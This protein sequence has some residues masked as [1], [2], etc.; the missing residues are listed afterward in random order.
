[1]QVKC[2]HPQCM[3]AVPEGKEYCG[4]WCEKHAR[5]EVPPCRCAHGICEQ[6][7]KRDVPKARTDFPPPKSIR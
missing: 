1:M 7:Y 2:A 5:E 3:C 4:D 6:I